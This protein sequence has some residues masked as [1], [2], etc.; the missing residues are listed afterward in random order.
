[1]TWEKPL[2]SIFLHLVFHISLQILRDKLETRTEDVLE[3]P[4]LLGEG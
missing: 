1:M 3:P 2:Y 4:E